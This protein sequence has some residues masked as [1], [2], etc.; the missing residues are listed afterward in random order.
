MEGA[1]ADL[2]GPATGHAL[3]NDVIVDF[4]GKRLINFD[5]ECFHGFRLGNRPGNTVENISVRTIR[6]SKALADDVYDDIVRNKLASFHK[7][8]RL[9]AYGRAILHGSPQDV[10]RG[11]C[12]NG[13]QFAQNFSLGT[14][15]GTRSSE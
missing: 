11:D 12:R 5:P 9:Q 10:P 8:L 13:Q 7:G 14:L 4:N 6:F 2:A 1:V 15:P 3:Y